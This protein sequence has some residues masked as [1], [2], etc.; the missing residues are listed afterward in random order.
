MPKSP[1]YYGVK[2]P[3]AQTEVHSPWNLNMSNSKS[4]VKEWLKCKFSE[5]DLPPISSTL[6]IQRWTFQREEDTISSHKFVGSLSHWSGHSTTCRH[7]LWNYLHLIGNYHRTYLLHYHNRGQCLCSSDLN[8]NTSWPNF[9]GCRSVCKDL[10]II[11]AALQDDKNAFKTLKQIL[12]HKIHTSKL[13][14]IDSIT[15]NYSIESM[16]TKQRAAILIRW[17]YNLQS[18]DLKGWL[19]RWIDDEWINI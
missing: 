15:S 11:W 4:M 8:P 3:H 12:H 17:I 7:N 16:C 1:Q 9:E 19:M 10:G 18:Q 14:H 5:G 6:E 2:M 13:T